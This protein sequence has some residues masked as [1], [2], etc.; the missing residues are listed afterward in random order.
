MSQLFNIFEDSDNRNIVLFGTGRYASYYMEVYGK[1]RKPIFMVDNN[2]G[3]WGNSYFGCEIKNPQVLSKINIDRVRIIIAVKDYEAIL[4][5]LKEIGIAEEFIRVLRVDQ[6]VQKLYEMGYAMAIMDD[7]GDEQLEYIRNFARVCKRFVIGIPNDLIM[8]RLYTEAR[9]Y[10]SNIL[11]DSL[12][13]R[14]WIDD[15]VT[16]D[17]SHLRYPEMHKELQ[18]DACLYGSTYGKEFESD[19]KYCMEQGVEFI[20]AI[21]DRRLGKVPGD[22]LELGIDNIH[23]TTKKIVI[24]GTGLYAQKFLQEYPDCPVAYAIDSNP[25]LWGNTFGDL[26]VYSPVKLRDEVIDNTVVIICAKDYDNIISTIHEYGDFHYLTM[27]YRQEIALLENFGVVEHDEQDYIVKAHNILYKLVEEFKSVCDEYGLHYYII[28][29]SLIGVLRHQDMV[30]WDDDIDIAMPRADY[31]KLKKI[32]KKRWD[33]DTFKFLDYK[34]YGGGAFLDCMPRLFYLKS[35]LPTKVFKKVQGK[36]TADVADRMFLDIYVMDNAHPNPKVHSFCMGCMKGIYNLC[37]GH[38]G[39][40]DYSE[41][42]GYVSK[43]ILMLMK[44]L[45]AIGSILPL[46]FLIWMYECFSQSANWNK[47]CDSYFMNSCAITCIERTFKKEFFE[48]GGHGMLH[49]ID[50]KI[51]K[52]PDGLFTAMHYGGLASIMNYPPYSIR[53]PSHYFNCDIEI[54]R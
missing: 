29:G 51:P 50:V 15:V 42:E 39:V 20:S 38:R 28:C 41:Y 43:G 48:E 34:D 37:M 12:L 21:P 17:Y 25:D 30:P 53:K 9:G 32:A 33:N 16:L 40:K 7:K 6:P 10:N 46:Q 24:Y 23:T 5:Q 54:W 27:V 2:S 14:E 44:T 11:T 31:N 18:F 36:A 1:Y 52:D 26:I 3:K 22:P 8:G 4:Q 47:K 49:G 35:K 45:H 19:K 13:S